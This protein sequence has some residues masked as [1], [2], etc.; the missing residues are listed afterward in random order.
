M[1]NLDDEE[2]FKKAAEMMAII[3]NQELQLKE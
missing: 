2:S 3:E 1:E